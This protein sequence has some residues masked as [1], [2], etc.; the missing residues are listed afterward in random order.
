LNQT[1]ISKAIHSIGTVRKCTLEL[2]KIRESRGRQNL[3]LQRQVILARSRRHKLL[4]ECD[5]SYISVRAVSSNTNVVHGHERRK[6]AN[7]NA[8]LRQFK[9]KVH[10]SLCSNT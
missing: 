10:H 5:H 3:F 8:F 4:L 9:S 6:R 7:L 1:Q 2:N